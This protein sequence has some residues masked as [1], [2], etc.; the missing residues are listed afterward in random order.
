MSDVFFSIIERLTEFTW[1]RNL[2]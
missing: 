1:S 2:L